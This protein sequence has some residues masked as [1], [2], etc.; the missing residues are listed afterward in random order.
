MVDVSTTVY[1]GAADD[2]WRAEAVID[3]SMMESVCIIST[4]VL[5]DLAFPFY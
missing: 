4:P 3:D 2:D 1:V 5:P